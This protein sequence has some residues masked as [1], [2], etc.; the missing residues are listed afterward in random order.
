M[1]A[2]L[3]GPRKFDTVGASIALAFASLALLAGY[4]ALHFGWFSSAWE[5]AG[6]SVLCLAFLVVRFPVQTAPESTVAHSKWAERADIERADIPE[7]PENADQGIYLGSFIDA[8]G[9]IRLRY[10]GIKHLICFGPTGSG[11]SMSIIT[12]N[13]QNLRRSMIIIDPK[14][15]VTAITA[16]RRKTFGKNVIVLNPFGVLTK[17]RRHMKSVGWNPLRQ[18][19][20]DKPTFASHAMCIAD[21]IVEGEGGGGGN[22]A[23]FER[24]AKNLVQAL[25]MWERISNPEAPNLDNIPRLL[26][27]PDVR[28]PKTKKL[29]GGFSYTLQE[30]ALCESDVVRQAANG[31]KT[32][33]ED[34][35]SQATSIRDVIATLN[36]HFA[37]MRDT[38]IADDMVLISTEI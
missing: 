29:T 33:L 3:R 17:K 1:F 18:L 16:R 12:P 27:A 10:K 2:K 15:D 30:M 28:D 23:F 22:A 32:R 36:S 9:A 5:L 37:F 14:G 13:V 7:G 11:K 8:E 35:N 4:A 21:A 38:R 6:W 24:S 26:N 25:I 20:P 19:Q 31:L 34:K